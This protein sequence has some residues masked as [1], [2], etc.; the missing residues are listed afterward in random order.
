MTDNLDSMELLVDLVYTTEVDTK[1]SLHT[2]KALSAQMLWMFPG[3]V[4]W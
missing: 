3:M 2:E 1:S 4:P